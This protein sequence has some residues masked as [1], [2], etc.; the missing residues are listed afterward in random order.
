MR[1]RFFAVFA[2]VFIFTIFVLPARVYA[3]ENFDI[4]TNSIYG[5]S[6]NGLT[7]VTQT[8]RI[9]NKTEFIYTPS[10]TVTTGINDIT[11]LRIYNNSGVIPHKIENASRGKSIEITFPE[12]VVGFGRVNEFTISFDTNLIA[13]KKGNIWEV[14]I[15][16]L[17]RPESFA[18]Y[19]VTLNIPQSFDAP[20]VVKP[21]RSLPRRGPYT[22][23]KGEIGTSGILILFGKSQYY[24]LS[25]SYHIENTRIVPVKTEIAL[26]PDTLYQDIRIK[27]ITPEP[28]DVYEDNDGNWLAVYSLA[29]RERKTIKAEIIARVFAAP[30]FELT[31]PSGNL[32]ASKYWEVDDPEI[33]KIAKELKTPENIYNFVVEKLSYNYDKV[34]LKN[35]RVGARRA[36]KNPEF[37]VCLEFT[38]LFVTL[39]RA[40]GIRARSVEGYAHTQD[41]K[42]R[43]LSLVQDVLHS[44][45][46]YYDE[47]RKAWVMIDPTWADTTGGMDYFN[48]L[49][50][51]HIAFVV[52][53]R[54]SSYPVPAGGYKLAKD[55]KDVNVSFANEDD[56]KDIIKTGITGGFPGVVLPLLPVRGKIVLSNNGNMAISSKKLYVR[57][58]LEP[59]YQEF[60]IDSIPPYG[61]KV[62]NVAFDKSPFLTNRSHNITILF[63]GNSASYSVRVGLFPD[64]YLILL[65][66]VII[67]GSTIT[68]IIAYKTWCLYIQR[69]K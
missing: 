9:R 34:D 54:D 5:V 27:S 56:F 28:D 23:S 14:S 67:F 65:G 19:N 49:D 13:R 61:K 43:P 24:A 7:T 11:N 35:Q 25:L 57:S 29:P 26:P 68:A 1:S 59:A 64:Q 22:F 4:S 45:P 38:D 66:G 16:G 48:S 42:L 10:Y 17:I 33:K 30:K 31:Q 39:A 32:S 20:S 69:R 41:P 62:I 63:D 15:P 6:E 3:D 51:D 50:F 52:K 44:W 53:G 58:D 60:Y 8:V 12:R 18:E 2:I 46:E 47:E 36:L 37:A 21:N 55:T 40:A